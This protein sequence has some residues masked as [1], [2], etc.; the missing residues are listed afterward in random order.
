VF[1]FTRICCAAPRRASFV[2]CVVLR[3]AA[4]IKRDH[5]RV[6]AGE[7]RFLENNNYASLCNLISCNMD[8][9]SDVFE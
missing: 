6:R 2:Q 8:E 3:F 5:G 4:Y 7:I 9:M 1:S